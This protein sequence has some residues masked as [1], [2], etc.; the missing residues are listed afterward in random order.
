MRAGSMLHR[1]RHWTWCPTCRQPPRPPLLFAPY[2]IP[3][4]FV[5]DIC[6]TQMARGQAGARVRLSLTFDKH[7][8]RDGMT[9][10]PAQSRAARQDRRYTRV[11]RSQP[12]QENSPRPIRCGS[13]SIAVR[14]AISNLKKSAIRG[15]CLGRP[16]P[17]ASHAAILSM[18]SPQLTQMAEE[19]PDFRPAAEF[20]SELTIDTQRPPQ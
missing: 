19:I 3:R 6:I 20:F 8:S 18:R 2:L 12:S 5:L 7:R 10:A 11:V 9:D 14:R 1:D 16:Q 15:G 4:L 17:F 13:V